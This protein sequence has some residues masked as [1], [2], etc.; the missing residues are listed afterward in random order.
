VIAA[1]DKRVK[2]GRFVLLFVGLA[3][4]VYMHAPYMTVFLLVSLPKIPH[5]HRM[6]IFLAHHTCIGLARTV[7]IHRI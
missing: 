7:Y 4:T 6:Y 2:A 5:V 1:D 3:G